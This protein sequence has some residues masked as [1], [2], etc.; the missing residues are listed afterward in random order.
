MELNP[1]YINDKPFDLSKVNM[2]LPAN[3]YRSLPRPD[4]HFGI[5]S[6]HL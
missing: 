1:L 5:P 4:G 3:A 6:V 2:E